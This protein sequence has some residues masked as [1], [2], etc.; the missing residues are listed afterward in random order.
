MSRRRATKMIKR[1]EYL[2]YEEGLRE[3]RLFS[4]EKRRLRWHLTNVY[5]YLKEGKRGNA[6]KRKYRR[7]CLNIRK[8]IFTMRV[9]EHWHRFL[10][11]VVES[12]SM[13]IFKSHM[14]MLCKFMDQ[15]SHPSYDQLNSL[16]SYM[17][18]TFTEHP[19]LQPDTAGF[20]GQHTERAS[21]SAQN[22][23]RILCSGGDV[24]QGMVP[25]SPGPS[26]PGTSETLD[27]SEL[28][29]VDA[30]LRP[31]AV[32]TPEASHQGPSLDMFLACSTWVLGMAHAAS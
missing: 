6:H 30:A 2:S 29:R 24:W 12:P 27:Q 19:T 23:I 28:L 31:G 7:L 16:L 11:E 20:G 17:S 14:D 8:H 9:T 3:L 26:D 15:I 18:R 5:K 22:S 4:L 1:L 25:S 13:E 21:V 10:R 32:E